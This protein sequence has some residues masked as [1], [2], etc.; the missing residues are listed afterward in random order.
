MT[1]DETLSSYRHLLEANPGK[2][3]KISDDCYAVL[4]GGTLSGAYI[5]LDGT[6]DLG[7]IFEFDREGWDAE[8]ECWEGDVSGVQTAFCIATPS[9]V[10]IPVPGAGSST[11]NQR[12]K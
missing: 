4:I 9:L 7:T 12:K 1:Y 2:A 3:L 11:P 10:E 5:N 6:V 8:C